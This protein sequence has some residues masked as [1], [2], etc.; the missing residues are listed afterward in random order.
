MKEIVL[1]VHIGFIM[2]G[3]GRWAQRRFRPRAFGHRAGV[4]NMLKIC[5]HAFDLGVRIVTVYALSTEN[6]RRPKEEVEELFE[7]FRTYFGKKRARLL[8]LGV[9]FNV[10]GDITPLPEDVQQSLIDLTEE[11]KDFQ[12]G[13][14]N[15]CLNYGARQ[16]IVRATNAAVAAGKF[17]DEDS[18]K[19][20][21]MT[22]E[23][24]DPDLII[25]TGGEVRLS[26]F[27]LYQAAYSELYFTDRM[28]PA[29][30]RRDLEKAIVNFSARERRYGNVRGG[31]K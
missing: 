27:L 10:V 8:E 23:L 9:K 25:R 19:E 26:N 4:Q 3:N 2:D 12:G 6:L 14:L 15:I 1:P 29:F 31:K 21:L 16:E 24:P 11:S 5:E 7:L 28:W 22:G 17:V 13:L 18:F 20:L 30:S